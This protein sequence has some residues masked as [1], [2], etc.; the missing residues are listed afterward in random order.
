MDER[1]A[2][3]LSAP[4]TEI[5]DLFRVHAPLAQRVLNLLAGTKSWARAPYLGEFCFHNNTLPWVQT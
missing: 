2:L 4:L 1:L 5:L 3:H